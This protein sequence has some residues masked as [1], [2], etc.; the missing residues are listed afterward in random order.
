M[1]YVKDRHST[2]AMHPMRRISLAEQ[3]AEHLR[4]G[5]VAGRW[6]GVLPGVGRLAAELDISPATLQTALRQLEAEGWL[7]THGRGRNR[8]ITPQPEERG[9]LRVGILLFEP[10]LDDQPQTSQVLFQIQHDLEAAGHEVF[11]S[12]KTQTQLGFDVRRITRHLSA[13]PADAWIVAGGSRE[14]LEWFAG[15]SL[16][17]IALFGRTEG[18]PLA[19]TGPDKM[20]AYLAA[21]RHLLALGHRR[22]VLI[23]SRSRR[24]PAGNV[25][26][27]FLDELATHGIT[28]GEYHLP[29]WEES[30]EGFFALLEALF[31]STPPTALIVEQT[32]RVIAAVQFLTQRGIR[33]PAQVSLICTDYDVTLA[34]CPTPIA[35][36]RWDNDRIIRRIVRWVAALRVGR[37]DHKTINFPA[38]FIA[39]GS[40]GP[41]WRG[42]HGD[43]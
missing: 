23:S 15:Q 13:N 6:S 27:A 26:Q 11:F 8:S 24:N 30:P 25:E 33:V 34:W 16:P 4:A 41:V 39:G 28:T 17:C 5:L 37:A 3:C 18:L 9:G 42:S 36:I 12:K 32:P 40:I 20:D 22:I 38:E 10:P 7:G 19:R 35:H 43:E 2:G 31:R 21:T 1:N 14:L 29:D